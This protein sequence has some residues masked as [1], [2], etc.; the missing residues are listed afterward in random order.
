MQNL[1]YYSV[2]IRFYFYFYCTLSTPNSVLFNMLSIS[3]ENKADI[4]KGAI[5]VYLEST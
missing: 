4:E 1:S 3:D 5:Q 2:L